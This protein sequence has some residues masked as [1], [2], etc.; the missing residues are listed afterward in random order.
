M[1][2]FDPF[3]SRMDVQEPESLFLFAAAPQKE[4]MALL[5]NGLGLFCL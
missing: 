2:T 3:Q 4:E 5:V 1:L